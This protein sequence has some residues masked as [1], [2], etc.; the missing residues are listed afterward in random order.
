MCGMLLNVSVPCGH[1]DLE[2]GNVFVSSSYCKGCKVVGG[3]W[4]KDTVPLECHI[5]S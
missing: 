3:R 2:A 1:K 5:R 4:L